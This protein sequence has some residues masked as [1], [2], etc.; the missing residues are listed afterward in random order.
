MAKTK[1][2]YYFETPS[3]V[4]KEKQ[5]WKI[6]FEEVNTRVRH[7]CSNE[8][9]EKYGLL[10]NC[11][12]PIKEKRIEPN[13]KCFKIRLYILI[14]KR[15]IW[16]E[17]NLGTLG[18]GYFCSKNCLYEGLL[19]LQKSVGGYSKDASEFNRIVWGKTQ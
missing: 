18:R 8:K 13:E 14:G 12:I 9:C 3:F 19:Y 11:G 2:T 1:I 17:W 5:R 4:K 10:K 6:L 16:S 7:S 15:E